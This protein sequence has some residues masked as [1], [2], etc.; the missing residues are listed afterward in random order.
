MIIQTKPEPYCPQCGAR[1]RLIRPKPGQSFSPF[2]GCM[3]YPECKGA[4]GIESDGTPEIYDDE[5][6]IILKKE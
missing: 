4:R 6:P 2:W 1:M 3:G 5:Q